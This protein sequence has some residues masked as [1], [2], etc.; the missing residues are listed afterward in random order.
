MKK[1]T[2]HT[3]FCLKHP[4]KATFFAPPIG[5]S[6][7]GT[8]DSQRASAPHLLKIGCPGRCKGIKATLFPS[9]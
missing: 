4:S 1:S 3:V 9:K 2:G 7:E 8:P 6:P 5:S